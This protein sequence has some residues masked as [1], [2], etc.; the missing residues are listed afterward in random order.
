ML[1]NR[2]AA[3]TAAPAHEQHYLQAVQFMIR[4]FTVRSGPRLWNFENVE[5]VG[6]LGQAFQKAVTRRSYIDTGKCHFCIKFVQICS[7][8]DV[9]ATR[10]PHCPRQVAQE[11]GF[12]RKLM[13]SECRSQNS[14]S[15][16]PDLVTHHSLL[17][18]YYSA[19]RIRR[20]TWKM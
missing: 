16:N 14:G 7:K 17:I 20:A 2:R 9:C 1:A 13:N 8:R 18:T 5:V 15:E 19:S 3:L 12:R 10:A 4:C 6:S 11:S